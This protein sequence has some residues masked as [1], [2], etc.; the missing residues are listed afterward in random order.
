MARRSLDNLPIRVLHDEGKVPTPSRGLTGQISQIRLDN[1]YTTYVSSS[2]CQKSFFLP[3]PPTAGINSPDGG[4]MT[5]KDSL[6]G[7]DNWCR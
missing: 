4:G 5:D 6:K 2:D 1:I 3:M 7:P